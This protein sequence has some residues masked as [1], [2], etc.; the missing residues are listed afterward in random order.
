[1]ALS[2][3]RNAPKFWERRGPTSLALWPLSW[4]YSVILRIRKLI[5][6]LDIGR[7]EPAPVPIII[8]GNIRVG[9]TG[10]TPIV[11]ALAQ[12][13]SQLGW[14]PGIISRGYG[15]SVQTTPLQ[16]KSDS[17]PAEVGDEPVLIARRTGDQFPIWVFPKRQQSIKAMLKHS[18]DVNIIISDDGL[19]HRGLIRWPAREGG[20]DIELVARDDRGE[21]NRFLLPAGPLR[22]PATRERDAT[23]FTGTPKNQ[24]SGLLDEYFLGRRCFNLA[25]RLGMPYQLINISNTQSL[26]QIAEQ[27]SPKNITALAGLGNPQRFFDDLAKHGISGKYIPLPDHATFSP[28]FFTAIKSECILITE[29][30]AVKCA[31]IQDERIWVVPMLLHLPDNLMDWLQSILQRP[32]P[33][34]YTL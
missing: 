13:L 12:Q 21:G 8:I 27:F 9:G 18:P 28:D 33:R 25:S 14:K 4:L 34:R 24:K 16:V 29:K 3:F 30:D 2:I 17:D 11:I 6:D 19:Q 20:R 7:A 10:K 32:D 23:L 22:E 1:M 5:H 31:A 15:S 26:Q